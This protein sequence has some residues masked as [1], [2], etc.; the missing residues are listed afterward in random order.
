VAIDALQTRQTALSYR[1]PQDIVRRW[2]APAGAKARGAQSS[3]SRN[4]F[5]KFFR[6]LRWFPQ[7]RSIKFFQRRALLNFPLRLAQ[8][9]FDSDAFQYR[10]PTRQR[11]QPLRV[12][13]NNFNLTALN[14]ADTLEHDLESRLAV[15]AH[16][17]HK[18]R[19]FYTKYTRKYKN[20]YKKSNKYS[21]YSAF[22]A[23]TIVVATAL[24][25]AGL[26]F[27]PN[28]VGVA[29]SRNR[30]GQA[31]VYPSLFRLV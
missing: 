30:E 4:F 11:P 31:P 10:R 28:R 26:V 27:S 15:A 7:S 16:Q 8:S 18:T 21:I 14:A 23:R 13:P 24:P 17:E 2:R 1:Y 6:R 9:G 5:N 25:V 19:P 29:K 12:Q 22:S 3:V 20:S